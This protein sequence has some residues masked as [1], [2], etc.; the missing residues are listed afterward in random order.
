R[1]YQRLVDEPGLAQASKLEGVTE[2][3]AVDEYTVEFR[4]DGP[5]GP[6]LLAQLVHPSMG[7]QN[8]YAAAEGR[9]GIGTGPFRVVEWE[10]D[11]HLLMEA[12]DDYWMG[13]PKVDRLVIR[14]IPDGS[15][16]TFQLE[17]GEA[18]ISLNLPNADLARLRENPDVETFVPQSSS[19]RFIGMVVSKPPFDD[20]RVR[21]A[22]NY[23]VDKQAILDSVLHGVGHVPEA[24][25][26]PA[27]YLYTPVGNYP[28]DP[29]RARQLL[30]EAGYPDGFKTT[31]LTSNRTQEPELAAAVAG[32]LQEVGI[33]AAIQV[34]EFG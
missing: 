2:V 19:W 9:Y 33:D 5:M 29:E 34:V 28:Y 11:E 25:V 26:G 23:A 27:M 16:R 24:P 6:G 31:I 18:H 8:P 13:R 22:L 14:I 17:T 1:N 4:S 30:A 10:P 20:V 12:F 15:A 32:Y 7:V 21:Q 3:V